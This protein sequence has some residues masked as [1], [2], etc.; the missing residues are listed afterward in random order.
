MRLFSKKRLSKGWLT[1]LVLGLMSSAA[2]LVFAAAITSDLNQFTS[3]T[4]ISSSQVNQNFDGI[5]KATYTCPGN[6]P[7]DEMVRVGPLC[8]DKYEAS[9]WNTATGGGTQFGV[10][11]DTYLCSDNGNDCSA[12]E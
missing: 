5:V 7:T 10:G 9:V 4:T 6:D 11:S 8:V 3:G 12:G 1:G 2:L